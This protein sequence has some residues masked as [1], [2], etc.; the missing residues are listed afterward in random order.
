MPVAR[1]ETITLVIIR[2]VRA[3]DMSDK[4]IG[5]N[6]DIMTQ[7]H[8]NDVYN[9]ES[10]GVEPVGGAAR[11]LTAVRSATSDTEPLILFSGDIW[12]WSK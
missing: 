1:A 11:F 12:P 6:D 2:A 5:D 4:M 8:F 9:V 10:R 7:V 3:L